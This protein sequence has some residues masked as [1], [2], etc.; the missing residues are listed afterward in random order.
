MGCPFGCS[1][2]HRRREASRRSAQYYRTEEGREKKRALN[3]NRYRVVKM[4]DVD[5][6][7]GEEDD[8]PEAVEE[9]PIIE[10]VR[11]VTSL[12][13]GRFVSLDEIREMLEK[14]ERQ[15]SLTRQR[16]ADYLV[17]QLNKDP[18]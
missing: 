17:H 3:Q 8:A 14:K 7:V 18:P 16:R 6:D 13:E 15:H 1:E 2:S 5:P 10:Y 4:G 12:I 11:M 9:E